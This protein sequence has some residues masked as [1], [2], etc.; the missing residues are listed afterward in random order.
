[1]QIVLPLAGLALLMAILGLYHWRLQ[2][3]ERSVA[4][5]DAVW[6][7]EVNRRGTTII[8]MDQLSFSRTAPSGELITCSHQF[9][10]GTPLDGF[11]VGDQITIVPATGTC[12]RADII[13]RITPLR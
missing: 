4:T 3:F 6:D 12:Q 9:E 11:K 8:T 2:H 5:I 1:M 7:T 13:G 10:I